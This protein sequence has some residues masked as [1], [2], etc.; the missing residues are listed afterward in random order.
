M[1]VGSGPVLL[2]ETEVIKGSQWDLGASQGFR[3]SE[4]KGRHSGCQ[5]Y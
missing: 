2:E 1:R 4:V 3:G 5:R